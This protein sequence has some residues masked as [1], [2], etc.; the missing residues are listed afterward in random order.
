MN[1]IITIFYGIIFHK[2]FLVLLPPGLYSSA[3]LQM[4]HFSPLDITF[5]KISEAKNMQ[6]II[7]TEVMNLNCGRKETE[8]EIA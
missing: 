2:R 6:Y 7:T 3:V 1:T 5:M 4:E 8:A